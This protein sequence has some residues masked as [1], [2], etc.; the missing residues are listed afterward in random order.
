MAV[1]LLRFLNRETAGSKLRVLATSL[2][3]GLSRG[4]LLTT[5]NAA[6]AAGAEGR[7]DP[8]LV[9]EFLTILAVYLATSYDAILQ[10]QSLIEAMAQRLRLR[11]S[12]KLLLGQLRFIE[13]WGSGE[14]Y[15]QVTQDISRL[16]SAAM[17]FINGFQATVLMIFALAYLGWLTPLG[18]LAAVL[19][20]GAGMATYFWQDQSATRDLE[21]ARAKEAEFFQG[22]DD[23]LRGFKEMKQS[24]AR[25]TDL[26]AHLEAVSGDYRHLTVKA[27]SKFLFTTLTSQSFMFLLVA[28]LVFALP[29]FI[30]G[31]RTVI[32]QFLA[33]IL[34]VIG[35]LETLV[36]SIPS[37]SKA[38]VALKNVQRL[39]RELDAGIATEVGIEGTP[40]ATRFRTIALKDVHFGFIG[41]NSEESFDV[42]PVDLEIRH[43]EVL[44]IVGG[45]GAGKTTLLKL[46]TGL[47]QPDTGTV[48]FNDLPVAPPAYQ[49][50]REIFAA[51][52]GDFH[53]F[54]RLYGIAMPD[55]TPLNRLLEKLQIGQKT[56]LVDGVFSTT[57]LSA[58][59]RKRLAYA[60]ARLSDRQIY[61]FDEFAADQD[62]GFRR[63]FYSELVPELKRQGKTV[64]AVTHDD[65]WFEVA[66]RVVKMD[67]GRIVEVSAHSA[68][69]PVAT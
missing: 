18:L 26:L 66:D 32:F 11:I 30:Q 10:G 4:L 36:S 46:L 67:Y 5:I 65:R 14:I 9:L 7:F 31:D 42:G 41:S 12:E 44:F 53:L 23:L 62:P 13:T 3:S 56:R 50:Y 37:I 38:G 27:E 2:G 16:S 68:V 61:V 45:N 59:Q 17:T 8:L 6:A 48:L 60:V 63:F 40:L 29:A 51:V 55:P 21:Q 39:E 69:A 15:T 33:T 19:A 49:S 24:R 43:G 22:I 52:F 1:E 34:F 47:Y 25:R 28:V 54:R 35:P 58:G 64:V 57:Q 20:I